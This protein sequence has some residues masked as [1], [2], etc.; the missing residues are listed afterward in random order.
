MINNQDELVE[1]KDMRRWAKT[2]RRWE[3]TFRTLGNNCSKLDGIIWEG[4]RPR[5]SSLTAGRRRS[6]SGTTDSDFP[7]KWRNRADFWWGVGLVF[8][9][10]PRSS[11][12]LLCNRAQERWQSRRE[13]IKFV[14]ARIGKVSRPNRLGNRCAR[15]HGWRARRQWR[16]NLNRAQHNSRNQPCD[17]ECAKHRD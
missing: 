8:F 15:T 4:A 11:S 5:S 9:L 14:R 2:H 3:I 7:S 6:F 13:G 12:S 1:S 16:P 17:Q 10:P